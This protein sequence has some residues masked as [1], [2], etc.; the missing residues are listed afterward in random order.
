ML[1]VASDPSR[2]AESLR[3][4]T[5][6]PG[7]Q[8]E[9][10]RLKCYSSCMHELATT[11]KRDE[12]SPPWPL[13]KAKALA[14]FACL[15]GDKQ[16][17]NYVTA[18]DYLYSVISRLE[19]VPG[20]S[21]LTAADK[22][23]LNSVVKRQH[24]AGKFAHTQAPGVTLDEIAEVFEC[25]PVFGAATL[26]GFLFGLR[27][28][29]LLTK[30][31]L[32]NDLDPTVK[33]VGEFHTPYEKEEE[34]DSDTEDGGTIREAI[35][36]S[37]FN[38]GLNKNMCHR[39]QGDFNYNDMAKVFELNLEHYIC[40]SNYIRRVYVNCFCDHPD[41]GHLCPHKVL[42]VLCKTTEDWRENF[43]KKFM[44]YYGTSRTQ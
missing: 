4:I 21:T 25:D 43:E 18:D 35:F 16:L 38:S 15:V 9:D 2:L 42:P 8:T 7:A 23:H 31:K 10:S 28:S 13:T 30:L 22:A 37:S 6:R 27:R 40:K 33:S 32:G 41:V 19:T 34:P 20:G 11:T 5:H 39:F 14:F 36:V 44:N 29:T 3:I 12:L 17:P 26:I 1:E 24:R